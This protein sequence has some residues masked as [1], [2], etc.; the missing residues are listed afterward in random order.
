MTMIGIGLSL[1]F[2]TAGLCAEAYEEAFK[3]A[4]PQI[5]FDSMRP[6]PVEGLYEVS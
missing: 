3:N 1:L 4:Y 5:P 2:V 6:T